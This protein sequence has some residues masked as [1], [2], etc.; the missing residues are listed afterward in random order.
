MTPPTFRSDRRRRRRLAWRQRQ[1]LNGCSAAAA[2]A[3]VVVYES[4]GGGLRWWCAL[5][6]C[7][8]KVYI[9]IYNVHAMRYGR[10]HWRYATISPRGREVS[11][12]HRNEFCPVHITSLTGTRVP[13][14]FVLVA[15]VAIRTSTRPYTPA[16]QDSPT[17][18]STSYDINILRLYRRRCE[19]FFLSNFIVRVLVDDNVFYSSCLLTFL[20]SNDWN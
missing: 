11:R 18:A 6:V 3:A 12:T 10:C 16:L 13:K 20:I 15:M 9:Y 17:H 2:A 8:H 1:T 4:T 14:D 5:C 7:T 19:L